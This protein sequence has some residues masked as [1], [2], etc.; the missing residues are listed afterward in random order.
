MT[1]D[2]Q[3]AIDRARVASQGAVARAPCGAKC[4]TLGRRT[5]ARPAGHDGAHNAGGWLW[6]MT[7]GERVAA[8]EAGPPE[9]ARVEWAEQHMHDLV[10]ALT[11]RDVAAARGAAERVL[12]ALR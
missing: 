7:D 1:A 4:E 5:C 2:L 6:E 8:S 12:E 3:E 11:D 9:D 10:Q